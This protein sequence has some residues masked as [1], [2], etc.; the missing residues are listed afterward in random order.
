MTD[1]AK[2]LG[3]L[4]GDTICILDAP[5]EAESAIRESAPDGVEFTDTLAGR[6]IA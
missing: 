1:L 2:K 5:P 6:V 4:P 3:I